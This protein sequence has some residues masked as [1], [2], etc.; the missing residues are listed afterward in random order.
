MISI[1]IFRKD[2]RDCTEANA[3]ELE[4]LQTKAQDE[5]FL[6]VLLGSNCY[7]TSVREIVQDC[8]A[9]DSDSSMWLAFS[10]A[11]CLF[12]KTG[13]PT[14]PCKSSAREIAS[15]TAQMSGE[16]YVVF[17]QFLQNVHTMCVFVANS[18]FQHRAEA[19]LN[20]LFA[21]GFAAA[22]QV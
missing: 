2:I 14:Y 7:T 10:M 21:T 17:S 16:D 4:R 1:C 11:N 15:C 13:R 5:G 3:G 20:S 18:D 22:E 12:A 9:M 19:M 6:D 8:N